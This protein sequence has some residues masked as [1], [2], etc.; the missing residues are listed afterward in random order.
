[1]VTTFSAVPAGAGRA[2]RILLAA[3]A[4]YFAAQA[5]LRLWIGMGLELD[6]AEL[7]LLARDWRIGYGPQ[8]PLYN[9]IQAG[10]FSLLGPTIPALTVTKNLCLWLGFALVFFALR[11][12]AGEAQAVLGTLSLFLLPDIA[13][14]AQ[15]TLSHSVAMFLACGACLAAIALVLTRGRWADYALLGIALGLGGLSKFN[16]FLL[17]AALFLAGLTLPR[18][19]GGQP[20]HL[21]RLLASL[22]IAAAILWK[23]WAWVIA[24]PA[25]ALGSSGKIR[26]ESE[27]IVGS[28]FAGGVAETAVAALSA[29]VLVLLAALALR[30]VARRD[31]A[32]N[33]ASEQG[34]WA[35]RLLARAAVIGLVLLA[36]GMGLAGA[37]RV[38]PRWLIP[39]SVLA[40]PALVLW[41]TAPATRRATHVLAVT[42]AVAGALVFA[43]L[44]VSRGILP[45]RLSTNFPAVAVAV[46][47]AAPENVAGD[48]WVMGNLLALDPALA[49]RRHAPLD[50][51]L[52]PGDTALVV[53]SGERAAAECA[54]A[55]AASVADVSSSEVLSVPDRRDPAKAAAFTLCR[56]AVR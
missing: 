35:M 23:P 14:E 32:A 45:S 46:A 47:E 4:G 48:T 6:E 10:G 20:L 50:P 27:A 41:A 11:R 52:M 37:T 22:G 2:G 15:R 28:G 9:W 36:V 39:L 25:I 16:F 29:L 26:R 34:A 51:P 3:L 53:L 33:A 21:A 18:M 56:A 8:L 31:A 17:P 49:V 43:G 12:L 5:A 30:A 19:P 24:N 44:A 7:I 54:V 38:T 1:M 40:A 55:L 13:W 42:A